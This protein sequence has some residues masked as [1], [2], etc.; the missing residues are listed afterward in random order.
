[1]YLSI[2]KVSDV[3]PGDVVLTSGTDTLFPKGLKVGHL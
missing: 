1:M 2:P 3:G